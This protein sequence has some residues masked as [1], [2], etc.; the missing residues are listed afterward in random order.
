MER[1]L[2]F[3]NSK[4]ITSHLLCGIFQI[5]ILTAT[6]A[7]EDGNQPEAGYY[8][9]Y[10]SSIGVGLG[11]QNGLI[12]GWNVQG[13]P[14]LDLEASPMGQLYLGADGRYEI[15]SQNLSG[16]WAYRSES[17]SIEFTGEL[18]EYLNYCSV[19]EGHY[20]I[21]FEYQDDSGKT[22]YVQYQKKAERPIPDLV[23]P[24]G[25]FAGKIRYFTNGGI[26]Q[27]EVH[28]GKVT[29]LYPSNAPGWG[30]YDG[31][32]VH[33]HRI[34]RYDSNERFP[35]IEIY[36]ESGELIKSLQGMINDPKMWINNYY[37]L[38]EYNAS[39]K[40][41]LLNGYQVEEAS[42]TDSTL[43]NVPGFSLVDLEGKELFFEQNLRSYS[44]SWL[45][46][47]HIIYGEENGRIM[48]YN[49]DSRES[50][51]ITELAARD[52]VVDPAAEKLL[53]KR[54]SGLMIH[55]LDSGHSD[56]IQYQGAD[57][58]LYGWIVP[59]IRWGPNGDEIAIAVKAN[60]IPEYA[61]F[62]S[63]ADGNDGR[64]LRN[65]K[66]DLILADSPFFYWIN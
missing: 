23:K 24:N 6:L 5:L 32:S 2:K 53:I 39:R 17:R 55:Y 10:I 19:R 33:I 28:S 13:V 22:N 59:I 8:D 43:E 51:L 58:E 49:I 27:V 14:T 31:Y 9:S 35:E 41:L 16:S 42:E 3:M 50:E 54:E 18:A 44:A 64:P 7:Q 25:A 52:L 63:T 47:D 40:L 66:G 30:G 56:T 1:L 62:M 20:I 48:K 57:L 15:S 29:A 34:N 11:M 4:G 26:S 60:E 46:P 21:Q 65:T 12:Q 36:D 37:W 38:G 45:D 61:F